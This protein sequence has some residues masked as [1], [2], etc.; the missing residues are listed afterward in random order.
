M[1]C[2]DEVCRSG[3]NGVL[4]DELQC[5]KWCRG[6]PEAKFQVYED[7]KLMCFKGLFHIASFFLAGKIREE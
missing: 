3:T 2:V 7:V 4:I 1:Y 6:R 5:I